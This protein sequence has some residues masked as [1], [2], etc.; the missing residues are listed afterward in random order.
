MSGE[1]VTQRVKIELLLEACLLEASYSDTAPAETRE[2]RYT[3]IPAEIS[4]LPIPANIR[5]D[6]G[7]FQIKLM[8][9]TVRPSICRMPPNRNSRAMETPWLAIWLVVGSIICPHLD[10]AVGPLIGPLIAL[11]S[12]I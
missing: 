11:G 7:A 12:R 4:R 2:M 1:R 6:S 10:L 9:V 3:T 8:T 5:K